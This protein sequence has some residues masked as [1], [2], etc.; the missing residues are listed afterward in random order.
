M[1]EE[2]FRP[3]WGDVLGIL[4]VFLLMTIQGG[5]FYWIFRDSEF[6]ENEDSES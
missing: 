2:M 3:F 6:K 4:K 1:F 5:I